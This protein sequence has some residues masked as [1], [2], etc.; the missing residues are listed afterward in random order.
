VIPKVL[1]V[2]DNLVSQELLQA[3]V[4]AEDCEVLL[5]ETTAQGVEMARAEAPALILMDIQLPDM[6][7]YEATRRLRAD[8]QTA[9]IPVVIVTAQAMR[10]D[11]TRGRQAGCEAH[12]TKPLEG[13]ILHETLCRFLRTSDK[14]TK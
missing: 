11:E 10:G 9:G 7:G 14:G 6:T 12:L 2:E 1:I 13:R 8:P 3:L 5:A 4:E